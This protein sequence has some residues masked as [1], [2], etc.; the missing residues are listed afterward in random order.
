[1]GA[2]GE[3][4]GQEELDVGDGVGRGDRD[5]GFHP[6]DLSGEGSDFEQRLAGRTARHR[7][8]LR[9]QLWTHQRS[10]MVLDP[11]DGDDESTKLE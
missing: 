6:T 11:D 4:R 1:M 8:R 10:V 7:P 9:E 3:S 5:A 2:L